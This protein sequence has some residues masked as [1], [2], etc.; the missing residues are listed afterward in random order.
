M[1]FLH[2]VL[3]F[4]SLFH[5]VIG[6]LSLC[7]FIF[8]IDVLKNFNVILRYPEENNL[9]YRPNAGECSFTSV[10]LRCTFLVYFV[11]S[12]A[13]VLDLCHV[14][15]GCWIHEFLR[16]VVFLI[17]NHILLP[18]VLFDDFNL[19]LPTTSSTQTIPFQHFNLYILFHAQATSAL[20]RRNIQQRI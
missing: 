20:I 14:I 15:Q 10:M 17:I 6:R 8:T 12:P 13:N 4:V 18:P 5:F 19:L 16:R 3:Y 9:S 1:L 11:E 7:S 2:F